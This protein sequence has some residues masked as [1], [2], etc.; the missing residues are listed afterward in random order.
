MHFII[1]NVE[2]PEEKKA[3]FTHAINDLIKNVYSTKNVKSGIFQDI[4]NSC[5]YRYWEEWESLPKMQTHLKS[6]DLCVAF[7]VHAIPL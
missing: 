7:F 2:I 5:H 3:E 6:R 1:I 4:V